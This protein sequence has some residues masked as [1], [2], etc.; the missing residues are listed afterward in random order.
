M[1]KPFLKPTKSRKQKAGLPESENF[2]THY[3][4]LPEAVLERDSEADKAKELKDYVFDTSKYP[5]PYWMGEVK[6]G[7]F[8]ERPAD[9]GKA[10]DHSEQAL[11]MVTQFDERVDNVFAVAEGVVPW[12]EAQCLLKDMQAHIRHLT[13]D[14]S[15]ERNNLASADATHRKWGYKMLDHLKR[16]NALLLEAAAKIEWL[17]HV[18]HGG[19]RKNLNYQHD[20]QIVNRI[21]EEATQ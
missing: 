19:D 20:V 6:A 7:R 3:S 2:M 17:L 14:L 1:Q 5:A 15:A 21:R 4:S 10:I 18:M 16:K 13:A 9:D 8:F 11:D 12:G